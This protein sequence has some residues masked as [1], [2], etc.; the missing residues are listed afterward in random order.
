MASR[1]TTDQ[2]EKILVDLGVDLTSL[3]F[4]DSS[5]QDYLSKLRE[6]LAT[7]EFKAKGDYEKNPKFKEQYRILQEEFLRVRKGKRKPQAK[8][9]KI[10]ANS[11]KSTPRLAAKTTK[12]RPQKLLPGSAEVGKE[13][14]EQDSILKILTDISESVKSIL[15]SLKASNNI[16]KNLAEDERKRQESKKRSGAESKLEKKR[17]EGL[18]KL[19]GKLIEPIKGPLDAL[20]NFLKNVILGRVVIG[21]IDWLGNEENQKKLESLGRFFMDWWPTIVTAVLLFGTG[22]GGLLKSIVG[23]T[24][25]FIPKLLGLLPGL[26]KFLKSPMGRLAT[27]GVAALGLKEKLTDGGKDK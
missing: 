11:L 19:G 21:I 12:I 6:G 16:S 3:A 13:E 7:I 9:T 1:T 5:E 2:I 24:F 15:Y 17:F 4:E 22:L 26:L 14:P 27:L 25:K 23:I 10:S 8:K 20:F 18:K